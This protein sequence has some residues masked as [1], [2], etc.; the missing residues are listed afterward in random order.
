MKKLIFAAMA[1]MLMMAMPS[2]AQ[3]KFGIKAGVNINDMSVD[4]KVLSADNRTGFYVGPTVRFS[5]PIVGLGMDA[6]L[7]YD[8]RSFASDAKL[9]D[10]NT[11]EEYNYG[12]K[13]KTQQLTIPVNVRYN[14]I[15]TEKLA[16]LYIYGGPQIAFNL[17]DKQYKEWSLKSSNFSCN[18][19]LGVMVASRIQV[20]ANYNI[21]MGKTGEQNALDVLKTVQGIYGTAAQVAAEQMIGTAKSNA[22]QIGVA[23]YF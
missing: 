10:V 1:A 16:A 3:V 19:G 23:Y 8:Q 4:S 5:L 11:Q 12:T 15:G 2:Q 13:M 22:W 18:V 7:L 9:K 20:S 21:A 17:G 6:S 14:L